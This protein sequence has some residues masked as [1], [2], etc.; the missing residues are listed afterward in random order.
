MAR[1]ILWLNVI[2]TLAFSVL[3]FSQ[4]Q[5]VIG[6]WKAMDNQGHPE[7]VV[8]IY[9]YQGKY[10]GRMLATYGPQ[11]NIEDTIYDPKGRAPAVKGNPYYSGMDFM[12]GLK[13]EGP[14]YTNGKILDPEKGKIYSAEMWRDKDNLIVRGEIWVFGE[15]QTWLPIREQD[16]PPGFKKPD[17][18][19]FVPVIPQVQM[20]ARE[21]RTK[22]S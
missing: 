8:A 5:D 1:K 11:G 20:K 6:I 4:E 21:P 13:K 9:E 16:L 12:W 14:K 7:S 18:N 17:L 22:P 15:N 3:L 2:W 10:Y 19:Q